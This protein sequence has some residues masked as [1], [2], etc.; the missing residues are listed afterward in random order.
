MY[1][2]LAVGGFVLAGFCMQAQGTMNIHRTNGNYQLFDMDALDSVGYQTSPPP[3]S[4]VLY[5]TGGQPQSLPVSLIDS[6]TY[7]PGGPAGTPQIATGTPTIPA[8][9]GITLRGWVG[10]EGESEVLAY[11]FC[12]GTSPLPDLNGQS[13]SVAEETAGLIQF[14]V[15]GLQPGTLYYARAFTTNAQGTSYGNQVS[16]TTLGI[17]NPALTY[18]TLTDQDGNTYATIAIG[19]QTW[20]AENL[21]T[22]TYANGDPIPHV[23]DTAGWA[24]LTTGAW[25]H[26]ENTPGYLQAYGRLYNSYAVM[27]PRNVCPTGWHVPSDEEW[28]VLESTLGM[29]GASLDNTGYRGGSQ[30]VGGKMKLVGQWANPNTGANNSSGFSGLPAGLRNFSGTYAGLFFFGFWW[31]TT[32]ADANSHWVRVLTRNNAG[33]SRDFGFFRDGNSVRCVMD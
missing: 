4:I 6:I 32:P 14:Q 31:S 17:L 3:E 22:T 9:Y 33:I 25:S 11:G 30:N 12:Y 19:T 13:I 21:R 8:P 28:Q 26:V 15:N 10:A 7:S 16:F 5:I 20:M 2:V 23:P 27:D 18:G 1:R 24:A 29:P